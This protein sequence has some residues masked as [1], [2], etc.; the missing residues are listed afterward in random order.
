MKFL[1]QMNL[2]LLAHHTLVAELQI[3]TWLVK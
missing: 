1:H 2:Y 3:L